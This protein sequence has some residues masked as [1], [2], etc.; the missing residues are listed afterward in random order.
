MNFA[1]GSV[2]FLELLYAFFPYLNF[3]KNE[4]FHCPFTLSRT[5]QATP[6]NRSSDTAGGRPV[7][8]IPGLTC[9]S[10][11]CIA[12]DCDEHHSLSGHVVLS[13]A[14]FFFFFFKTWVS[15]FLASCLELLWLLEENILNWVK[16]P[17]QKKNVESRSESII[18][19]SSVSSCG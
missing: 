7:S 15:D 4:T 6:E 8:L 10:I 3:L 17:K 2:A 12:G 18:V 16:R 11:V 19:Y 13:G 5:V 9:F 14:F 1:E